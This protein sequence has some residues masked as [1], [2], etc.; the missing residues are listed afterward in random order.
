MCLPVDCALFGPFVAVSVASAMRAPV[1]MRFVCNHQ[2]EIL[3]QQVTTCIGEFLVAGLTELHVATAFECYLTGE[4][5]D[6]AA[7]S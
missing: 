3:K 1:M 6:K 4:W 7:Q 5:R 2:Q